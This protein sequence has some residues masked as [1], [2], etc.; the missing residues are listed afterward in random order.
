MSAL[1]IYIRQ[2]KWQYPMLKGLNVP[3]NLDGFWGFFSF[4]FFKVLIK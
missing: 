1:Y 2:E 3:I 4:L